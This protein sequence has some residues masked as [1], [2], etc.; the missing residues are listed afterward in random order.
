M[1][2][3]QLQLGVPCLLGA[4]A[5]YICNV[6]AN[7][8]HEQCVSSDDDRTARKLAVVHICTM[9]KAMRLLGST[10]ASDSPDSNCF[11]QFNAWSLESMWC[12]MPIQS[13]C[14]NI[15]A[16]QIRYC[17]EHRCNTHRLGVGAHSG[18]SHLP[19]DLHHGAWPLLREPTSYHVF[20]TLG[21]LYKL[22]LCDRHKSCF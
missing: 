7:L 22:V 2:V 6:A 4:D 9:S 5:R 19:A 1:V 14:I 11:V 8:L 3:K 12:D 13:C 18:A 20:D 10:R 17:A 16:Y 15:P 21:A